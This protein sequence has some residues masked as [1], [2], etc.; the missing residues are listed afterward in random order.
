M[1][2]K[3][4]MPR[5]GPVGIKDIARATG[6]SIGTV[7]RALHDKPGVSVETRAKVLAAAT[8]LGYKPNLAARHLKAGTNLRIAAQLPAEIAQFWDSLREGIREAARPF[9]PVLSV[10]FQSYPRMG[11]GDVP[12]I[13]QALAQ[14]VDGLIV[15][16]GDPASIGPWLKK[17]VKKGVAV[18]CVVTDAPD[19]NRLTSVSAEPA[20][21]GAMAGELMTRFL[22]GEGR[23]AF[24]TGWL[25]TQDHADKLRG[26]EESLK[27]VGGRLRIGTVVEAHDDERQGYKQALKLLK[28]SKELRG[29]YVS[30]VN[31]LPVLRA[32]E[33]AGRVRDV[34][35][36]T[37]DLFPELVPWIRCGAV[38][39]T[40]YQRP[41]S[42]GRLAV[43]ALY[44]Y[45]VEGE[46]PPEQIK[47]VPHIVMRSN[48]DLVLERVPA[49]KNG[50]Q[51]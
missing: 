45:L 12:L 14:G 4:Q 30:T 46:A 23:L 41:Q 36:V 3:S 47:V 33:E 26:F 34:T 19:T 38:A 24:F 20:T 50:H 2:P 9:E 11:D 15:A 29:I 35:V 42:Q 37:T 43:Q 31:S 51:G 25:G 5:T 44:R 1:S 21:V 27:Q 40:V 17:A 49:E 32:L 16:P 6:V 10:E 8:S 39:A 22:P 13:E 48:L 18:A 28:S 7:D